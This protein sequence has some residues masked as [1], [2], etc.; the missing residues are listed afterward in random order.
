M[1]IK[2]LP[3]ALSLAIF[4][5]QNEPKT[6][7]ET[8][9]PTPSNT[10]SPMPTSAAERLKAVAL[11]ET[12]YIGRVRDLVNDLQEEYVRAGGKVDGVGKVTVTVDDSFNL[13]IDNK[14]DGQTH[15]TKVNLK[16]LKHKENGMSAIPE[17]ATNKFPGLRI[18]TLGGKQ[19]VQHLKNGKLEKEENFITFFLT[20]RAAVEKVVPSMFQAI[21]IAT[22]DASSH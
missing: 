17:S 12:D 18:E 1:K 10:S 7:T 16:D 19:K 14:L 20:D 3:I 9:T 22:G 6:T 2:F 15:L 21:N 8:S 13:L 11:E 4:S 5:C